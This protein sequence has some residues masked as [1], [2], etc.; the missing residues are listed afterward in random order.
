MKLDCANHAQNGT[1]PLEALQQQKTRMSKQKQDIEIKIREPLFQVRFFI[2]LKSSEIKTCILLTE[3]L[4]WKG[5]T[6][7]LKTVKGGGTQTL[8]GT[9]YIEETFFTIIKNK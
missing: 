2:Q 4:F 3:K 1:I 6:R 7:A 5:N 8:L 9:C